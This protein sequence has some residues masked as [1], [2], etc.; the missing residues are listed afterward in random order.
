MQSIV[1]PGGAPAGSPG[2]F[3]RLGA[4]VELIQSQ[5]RLGGQTLLIPELKDPLPYI[6]ARGHQNLP[7]WTKVWPA[8]LVLAGLALSLPPSQQPV[9]EL[10]AGLGLPGLAAASKGHKVILSDLDPDALEF[11]RAAVELNGLE[12]R[13]QVMPLDWTQ[14]L[15]PELRGLSTVLGA[16]I[17]YQP[18]LYPGLARLL[19]QML[20]PGGTAFISHQARPFDIAF[21]K[22]AQEFFQIRATERALQ[23]ED[24]PTKV[25]LYALKRVG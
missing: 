4:R 16:E 21:F 24:G 1:E 13:V 15:A 5:V 8:A 2:A 11:A 19:A 6:E 17:L 9:L 22:M 3:D 10:G 14:P 7:Y 12:D 20:A 25:L 23:D 18:E